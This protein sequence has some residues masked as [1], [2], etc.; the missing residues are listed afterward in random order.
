[1]PNDKLS[2]KQSG[3]IVIP[4]LMWWAGVPLFAV[5][6]LWMLFFRG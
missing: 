6:I 2:N 5:I 1:M 4:A 3:G